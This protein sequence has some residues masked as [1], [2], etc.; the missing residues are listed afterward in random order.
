MEAAAAG[1]SAGSGG[2]QGVGDSTSPTRH[3]TEEMD[4]DVDTSRDRDR[5]KDREDGAPPSTAPPTSTQG[6]S[7]GKDPHPPG[8]KYRLTESMK[9]IVWEL[10]MLSNE[11]CQLENEKKS[12]SLLFFLEC[13]VTDRVCSA[14]EGLVIQVSEQGTRKVLYQK[15]VAAFPEGWMSSGQISRDGGWFLS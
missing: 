9:A 8:K 11:C 6:G 12:C 2:D 5:D 3:P 1:G 14:L 15:I 7:G 13:V 4:V 10:V